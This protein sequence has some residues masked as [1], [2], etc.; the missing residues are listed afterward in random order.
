MKRADGY[1]D[2]LTRRDLAAHDRLQHRDELRGADDRIDG[3]VGHRAVPAFADHVDLET[4][5]RREEGTIANADR[6]RIEAAVEMERERS[7]D[8]R[9][10]E[11][12]V[13]DHQ[14]V[15]GM[16]FLAGLKTEYQRSRNG[17]APLEELAGRGQQNR[18]CARRV[19]T[20]A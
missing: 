3:A 18:S 1:D 5:R 19:R 7:V 17:L 12:P 13:F 16:P 2:R 11:C 10:F 20:R 14:L 6:P 4:I 9:V 15:A 8:V